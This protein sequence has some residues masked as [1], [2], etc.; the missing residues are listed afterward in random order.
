VTP[1]KWR[2]LAAEVAMGAIVVAVLVL[3]VIRTIPSSSSSA[4]TPSTVPNRASL[5]A[6]GRSHATL[7]VISGTPTLKISMADLGVTGTLLRVTTPAGS[8]APRLRSSGAAADSVI[9]LSSAK[10]AAITVVLNEDVSWQLDLAAG[11]TRT[12]AD[13]RGGRVTGIDVTK[14]SD[15]V[16]LTLPQ[17]RGS[18]PV[19]LAAGSSQ[20]LLSRPTGVPVLV[21]AGAGAGEITLDGREHVGIAAGSVFA[22]T[23]YTSNAAGFAI[24]ATVG[25]AH[26]TVTTWAS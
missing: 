13:L 6:D 21:T 9:S 26:I 10:A 4:L 18:V 5:A 22:T 14:G 2:L 16:D 17:P 19:R 7:R 1:R 3:L 25:Q 12:V 8:T 20:L 23:A 24:D 11:T 15:I